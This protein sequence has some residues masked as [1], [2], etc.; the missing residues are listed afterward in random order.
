MSLLLPRDR[1]TIYSYLVTACQLV[2]LYICMSVCLCLL[3]SCIVFF[4]PPSSLSLHLRLT[5]LLDPLRFSLSSSFPLQFFPSSI[6]YS[7]YFFLSHS[8]P[9]LFFQPRS[10][11]SAFL[12]IC[13]PVCQSVCLFNL[14]LPLH[15]SLVL[16]S[17]PVFCLP[18][19]P[20]VR[21][22][23]CL[24]VCLSVSPCV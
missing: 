13:L 24:S 19:R 22:Y 18:V 20:S 23:V 2:C 17:A 21:L 5:Y 15:P 8:F 10:L 9:H 3:L 14:C 1:V 6:S 7:S 4:L 12:S 16:F 11:T